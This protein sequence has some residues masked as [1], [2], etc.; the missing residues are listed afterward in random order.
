MS[1]V[2]LRHDWQITNSDAN[3]QSLSKEH[4]N[5]K[6]ELLNKSENVNTEDTQ[7]SALSESTRHKVGRW[8]LKIL[9]GL[10]IAAGAA[11]GIA[12]IVT[13]TAIAGAAIYAATCTAGI[14]LICKSNDMTPNTNVIVNHEESIISPESKLKEYKNRVH[15]DLKPVFN[16]LLKKLDS[17]DDYDEKIIDFINKTTNWKNIS[18]EDN[19]AAVQSYCMKYKEAIEEYSKNLP[20]NEF[21]GDIC[22]F[23][24]RD[25]ERCDFIIDGK[26]YNYNNVLDV[27]NSKL[28]HSLDKK[29]VT[30]IL[31]Q[32]FMAVETDV[33]LSGKINGVPLTDEE[34][35]CGIFH[36]DVG[37]GAPLVNPYAP[38]EDG[39]GF[40][41]TFNDNN[42]ITVTATNFTYL[43]TVKEDNVEIF[44]R[45]ETTYEFK[46]KLGEY[47]DNGNI[48]TKP[49]I[50]TKLD[51]NGK[52]IN[53]AN[54]FKF[55]QRIL[56]YNNKIS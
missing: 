4:D 13:G 32:S 8:A 33:T 23:F 3:L 15:E 16:N 10:L 5:I 39:A 55:S 27:F 43:Q 44:G 36:R 47:E 31:N 40:N 38:G 17:D 28:T 26:K 25:V 41:L 37:M 54:D 56:P 9:G 29:Y 30:K 34:Q 18:S 12:A 19:N 45:I 50:F 22:K 48:K 20:D 24:S 52:P 49:C 53:E 42:T 21:E 2:S 14:A 7:N 46:I 11:V 51:L 1:E 35:K 6:N